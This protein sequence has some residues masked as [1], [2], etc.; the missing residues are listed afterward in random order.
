[1]DRTLERRRE[2]DLGITSL[3]AVFEEEQADPGWGGTKVAIPDAEFDKAQRL[4]FEKEMLGPL[5]ERP[6]A[7]GLRGVH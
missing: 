5:R 1:M 7:H 2:Q 4:A 6:P 3:F